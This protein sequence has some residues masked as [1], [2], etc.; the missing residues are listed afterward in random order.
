MATS[1]ATIGTLA[2]APR[3]TERRTMRYRGLP[4]SPRQIGIADGPSAQRPML[5]RSIRFD[6]GILDIAP[7]PRPR[8]H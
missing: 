1:F 6:G 5:Y 8:R 3:A 2:F 7:A 4:V